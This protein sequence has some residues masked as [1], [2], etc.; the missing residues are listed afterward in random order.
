LSRR[1]LALGCMTWLMAAFA[2]GLTSTP[3]GADAPRDQGWWTVTNS[4]PAPPDVPARGLLVQGGG[5]GAPTAFAAVLYE[6]DPDT[7]VG[8]LTL[9]VAPSSAT[10]PSTT[11]Q[12]CPLMQPITHAE[13]GGPMSD[14]P[15]YNCAHKVTA[16]PASDGKTYQFA[17]SGL[18]SDR[19]LAV[20]I[21]PTGPVD[22]V[23]LSAPD[24]SSLATQPGSPDTSSSGVDSGATTSPSDAGTA[25]VPETA[26]GLPATIPSPNFA[27]AVPGASATGPSSVSPPSVAAPPA[28]PNAGGT[29]V[30]AVA[31]S[32]EEATPL[33]VLL[34][35]AAGIGGAVLWLYAGRPRTDAAVI[36]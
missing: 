19:L 25:S 28:L 33:L 29:F 35:V 10:T 17:A 15:L 24:G 14:A 22:R 26:S 11:L 13:Q 36:G 7:T 23:V 5:G 4:L 9:T 32:S 31:A 34:F 8:S 20:A 21:L 2:I 1:L 27:D 18:V 12:L 16:A 6:L 3:A 30:P